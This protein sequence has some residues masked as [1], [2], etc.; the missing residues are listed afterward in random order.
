MIVATASM[1]L[2]VE[3]RYVAW[4]MEETGRRRRLLAVSYDVT[5]AISIPETDP[6]VPKSLVMA[7][8]QAIGG[9]TEL[10]NL[11]VRTEIV[12]YA[13]EGE[14]QMPVLPSDASIAAPSFVA[15]F[16]ALTPV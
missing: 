9:S 13:E 2:D 3:G 6:S 15:V 16:C 1:V 8:S 11:G 7:L 14:Q 10:A 12:S 4:G 5:V